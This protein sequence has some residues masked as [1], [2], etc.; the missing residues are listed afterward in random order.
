MST[1]KPVNS[2]SIWPWAC[3]VHPFASVQAKISKS[4]VVDEEV[5]VSVVAGRILVTMST[6]SSSCISNRDL[7]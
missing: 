3:T 6:V 1:V 7:T 2:G 4:H 5:P